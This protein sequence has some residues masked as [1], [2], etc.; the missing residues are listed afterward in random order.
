M[1]VSHSRE[2]GRV[3]LKVCSPHQPA[4]LVSARLSS[5]ICA[6]QSLWPSNPKK[7]IFNG[8]ELLEAM[9]FESYG[10]RD[11]D[12]IIAVP[13]GQS[14]S[15]Y[16]MNRWFSLTRDCD[17][18]NESMRCMFSPKTAGENARLRDL[19][20][21]K[22]E[23]KS[24]TFLKSGYGRGVDGGIVVTPALNLDYAAAEEPAT[25]PLPAQWMTE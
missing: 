17:S 23:G 24:R 25:E 9:T 20:L 15:I 14:D 5:R 7:F 4:R 11:G 2:L 10:I 22:V 18:F 12:S 21:F 19:R 8:Y 1:P 3:E 13:M 6:L 16:C